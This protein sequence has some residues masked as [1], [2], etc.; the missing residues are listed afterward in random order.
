[1]SEKV[2][3]CKLCDGVWTEL[4][5]GAVQ[6]TISHRGGNGHAHAYRFPDGSIHIIKKV[7]STKD[8]SK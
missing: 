4:P 6:L 7:P 2:F 8:G 3:V 5:E 1:M